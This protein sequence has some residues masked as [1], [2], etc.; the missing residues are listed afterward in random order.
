MLCI[1]SVYLFA[2]LF[3][4]PSYVS[5][6]GC[7]K[8]TLGGGGNIYIYGVLIIKHIFRGIKMSYYEYYTLYIGV[9][10][11]DLALHGN[12]YIIY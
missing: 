7:W 5:V 1:F 9:G 3:E 11:N 12:V 2:K 8:K 6:C 4:H 10:M